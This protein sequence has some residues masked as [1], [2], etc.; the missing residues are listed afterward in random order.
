M[1]MLTPL[2]ANGS[3]QEAICTFRDWVSVALRCSAN[4]CLTAIQGRRLLETQSVL[5]F[6]WGFLFVFWGHIY[7]SICKGCKRSNLYIS[8]IFGCFHI[9]L[10][11]FLSPLWTAHGFPWS[12]IV[13]ARAPPTKKGSSCLLTRNFHSTAV[14]C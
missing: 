11:E 4:P 9:F 6:C 12:V 13:A 3:H 1:A 5:Y 7:H 14:Y 10:A 8:M 2:S